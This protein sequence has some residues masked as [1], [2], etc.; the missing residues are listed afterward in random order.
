MLGKQFIYAVHR[1]QVDDFPCWVGK[2]S[3][4]Y[5][6]QHTASLTPQ[7]RHLHGTAL[8][9]PPALGCS[10]SPPAWPRRG[11]RLEQTQ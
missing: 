1:L 2:L 3:D 8:A 4:I 11:S 5:G 10:G 7:E 9:V 6:K